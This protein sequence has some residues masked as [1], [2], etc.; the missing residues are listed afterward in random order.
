MG[1]DI[2][3][4]G[5]TE[6]VLDE[7]AVSYDV[8]TLPSIE[9]SDGYEFIRKGIAQLRELRVKVEARR[10]E[11]KA[12]LLER[13]R[14]IDA[15][16]KDVLGRL[17]QIEN[18]M[19][20]LK[21]EKD[22]RK[23]REEEARQRAIEE[24]IEGMRQFVAFAN[25]TEDLGELGDYAQQLADM[26]VIEE[27]YGEMRE[28][29]LQVLAEVRQAVD[30][31]IASVAE[32]QVLRQQREEEMAAIEKERAELQALRAQV[33]EQRAAQKG[34]EPAQKGQEPGTSMPEPQGI[35]GPLA[36]AV[37]PAQQPPPCFVP[38]ESAVLEALAIAERCGSIPREEMTRPEWA[39]VILAAELR[40]Q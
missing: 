23:K 11:L 33:A 2:I 25:Q 8:Q 29:A 28:R 3:Q 5:V 26:D 10:K 6:A 37:P 14:E 36:G 38:T 16:A 12:P 21:R 20:A 35:A 1:K 27:Y 31:R 19:K 17:T 32:L 24:R 13:G 34:Q 15:A 30:A 39:C 22:E 40:Q 7:L 18:P 4:I 9:T